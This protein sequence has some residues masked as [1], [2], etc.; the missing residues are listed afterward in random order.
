MSVGITLGGLEVIRKR[1]SG[2]TSLGITIDG[3]VQK[4][5]TISIGDGLIGNYIGIDYDTFIRTAYFQQG[6]DKAFSELTSTEA[7]RKVIE[8]LGLDKWAARQQRPKVE[9]DRLKLVLAIHRDFAVKNVESDV[10]KQIEDIVMDMGNAEQVI[11]D[12]QGRIAEL[13]VEIIN[14]RAD[15]NN[16]STQVEQARELVAT[17][18]AIKTRIG[19]SAKNINTKRTEKRNL[20]IDIAGKE[21]GLIGYVVDVERLEKELVGVDVKALE[22]SLVMIDIKLPALE[23]RRN[24]I[25]VA[26]GVAGDRLKEL[27]TKSAALNIKGV[28]VCP[29]LGEECDRI[30]S[31]CLAEMHI[32]MNALIELNKNNIADMKA[33]NLA[34]DVVINALV[35]DKNACVRGISGANALLQKVNLARASVDHTAEVLESLR[36]M[37]DIA[38]RTI[39]EMVASHVVLV[40][41]L[42]EVLLASLGIGDLLQRVSDNEEQLGVLVVDKSA[43]DWQL[44]QLISSKSVQEAAMT[45]LVNKLVEIAENS[46][47]LQALEDEY[48]MWDLLSQAFGP[49]GVPAMQIDAMKEEVEITANNILQFGKQGVTIKIQLKEQK[50]AGEGTKDVFKILVCDKDDKELPLF[51][52]SGGEGYWVD[53]AVR[54][55]LYLVWRSKNNRSPLDLVMIDEGVGKV[56]AVKRKVLIDVL[57][58]M[59]TKVSRVMI[60]THSDVKNMVESFDSV[61][62]IRKNKDVSVATMMW[63]GV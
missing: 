53:L 59:T 9:M 14:K 41:E 51:R 3:I 49:N 4:F 37:A 8:I 45:A 16:L 18:E 27:E 12:L 39:D 15:V 13:D 48:I 43:L 6:K 1:S 56:D 33:T 32:S 17:E 24:E 44:T 42:D 5:P 55:A 52:F 54:V 29:V 63:G 26:V 50:K 58:Y 57:R 40:D 20:L 35:A 2:N 34:S 10:H 23:L 21:A 30:G 47:Q 61:I 7:R 62:T 36:R 22:T 38:E 11:A 46:K 25:S 28:G 60:I 19:V 31:E